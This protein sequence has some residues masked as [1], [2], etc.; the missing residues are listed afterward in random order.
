MSDHIL[1]FKEKQ[2]REKINCIAL[3]FFAVVAFFNDSSFASELNSV[4]VKNEL[5]D[6]SRNYYNDGFSSVKIKKQSLAALAQFEDRLS[7]IYTALGKILDVPRNNKPIS[8]VQEIMLRYAIRSAAGQLLDAQRELLMAAGLR[9]IEPELLSSYSH[10]SQEIA[11]TLTPKFMSFIAGMA[12]AADYYVL[13]VLDR[14]NIAGM[15]DIFFPTFCFANV[16]RK[17]KMRLPGELV[18]FFKQNLFKSNLLGNL[19]MQ[20]DFNAW[21]IVLGKSRDYTLA[22]MRSSCEVYA[23]VDKR[24]PVPQ[25]VMFEEDIKSTSY[26]KKRPE[27]AATLSKEIEIHEVLHMLTKNSCSELGSKEVVVDGIL[28]SRRRINEALAM[29][30][31]ISIITQSGNEYTYNTLINQLIL[32]EKLHYGLTFDT[33]F[34][35]LFSA[36]ADKEF[37]ALRKIVNAGGLVQAADVP[38]YMKLS[39]EDSHG[40]LGQISVD[41]EDVFIS[42]PLVYSNLKLQFNPLVDVSPEDILSAAEAS[43]ETLLKVQNSI[44]TQ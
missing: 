43:L 38:P 30:G 27:I 15:P 5:G 28:Y 19:F 29:I 23:E 24:G 36:I 21:K 26:L 16:V 35:E 10:S 25:V 37:N 2:M 42:V 41:G 34:V 3:V 32:S 44:C 14:K 22:G 33:F 1:F 11:V 9:E 7:S 13:P 6:E 4:G 18:S 31:T 17:E 39:K 20:E 8:F 12:N 40:S